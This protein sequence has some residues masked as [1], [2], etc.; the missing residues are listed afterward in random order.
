MHSQPPAAPVVV[1][2]VL[3]L[4]EDNHTRKPEL[5]SN[6]QALPE[7]LEILKYLWFKSLSFGND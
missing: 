7:F 4:P 2:R 5:E 3:S 6:N 1:Y